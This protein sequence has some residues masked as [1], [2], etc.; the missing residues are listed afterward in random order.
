V[1]SDPCQGHETPPHSPKYRRSLTNRI[2][3]PTS[4]W[5]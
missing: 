3:A 4:P 1:D 5:A 2:R